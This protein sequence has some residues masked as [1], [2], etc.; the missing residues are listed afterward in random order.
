LMMV[1]NSSSPNGNISNSVNDINKQSTVEANRKP[2]SRPI[3]TNNQNTSLDM[4]NNE[5]KINLTSSP[6]LPV[7]FNGNMIHNL[8]STPNQS[9]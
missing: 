2:S 4:P 3:V 7:A 9:I 8:N 6:I 5:N 1:S